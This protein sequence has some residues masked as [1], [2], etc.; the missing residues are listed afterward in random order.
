M[1]TKLIEYL[2]KTVR[3]SKSSMEFILQIKYSPENLADFAYF[4]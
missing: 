2:N 3:I 1:T 4:D